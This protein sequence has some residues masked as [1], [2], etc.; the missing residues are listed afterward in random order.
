MVSGTEGVPSAAK[1]TVSNHS[2]SVTPS[3]TNAA[4]YIAGGTHT[5]TAVTVSASEL[6]SGSETKTENGTY[7]V[8]N[9][10]SVVV[11]VSGGGGGASGTFSPATNLRSITLS[12]CVG[13]KNIAIWPT[14]SIVV[15]S[16]A[17]THYGDM[18][19]DGIGLRMTGSTNSGGTSW[20]LTPGSNQSSW[21]STTG[22]MTISATTGSNYGGYYASGITYSYHAW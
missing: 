1:G 2:V 8:T 16:G 20:S 21:N 5:G 9:L 4:G 7:D 11:N 12:D 3:V 18:W 22:T 6:V 14:T 13:K 10:A 15:I 19:I 17:R